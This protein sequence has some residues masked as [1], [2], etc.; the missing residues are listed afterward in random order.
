MFFENIAKKMDVSQPTF[1]S[2]CNLCMQKREKLSMYVAKF[3][4]GCG[5]I[6]NVEKSFDF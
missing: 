2:S 3:C 5:I 4:Y 1:K 6:F